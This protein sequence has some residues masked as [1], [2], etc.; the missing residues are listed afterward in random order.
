MRYN[1]II[2]IISFLPFYLFALLPL[3]AQTVP[4]YHTPQLIQPE[5]PDY[6]PDSIDTYAV[7]ADVHT[8]L[9]P[10]LTSNVQE[11]RAYHGDSYCYCLWN[12]GGRT[13]LGYVTR[14]DW[15]REYYGFDPGSYLEDEA[16]GKKYKLKAVRDLPLNR[17]FMMQ[18]P[19]GSFVTFVLEFDRIPDTVKSVSYVDVP[20]A[21][22][23]APGA[24][25]GGS[26]HP[27][28]SV[29]AL[30]QNTSILKYVEVKVV[31]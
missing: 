23:N 30:K 29:R 16:T 9:N 15:N 31:K 10:A 3:C 22:F 7:Y 14:N 19:A 6:N 28:L 11:L 24:Y 20:S 5:K 12:E 18:A 25:Y 26:T 27:H 2:K 4:Y 17:L 13:C 1:N 21:P 8:V